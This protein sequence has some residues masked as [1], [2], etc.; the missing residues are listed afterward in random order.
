[1]A[2]ISRLAPLI[3][4]PTIF[5]RMFLAEFGSSVD[6]EAIS[7]LTELAA[8]SRILAVIKHG[9]FHTFSCRSSVRGVYSALSVCVTFISRNG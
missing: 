4:P 5:F 7:S 8:L 9:D 3:T 1:M 6:S 2:V